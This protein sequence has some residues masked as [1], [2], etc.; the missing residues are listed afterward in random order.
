[1]Q[2][3]VPNGAASGDDRFVV[4]REPDLEGDE[5]PALHLVC[6]HVLGDVR[7]LPELRG[8]AGELQCLAER[9]A[10]VGRVPG[11]EGVRSAA[12]D[13]PVRRGRVRIS[14]PG[15]GRMSLSGQHVCI[16]MHR[17]PG[18]PQMGNRAIARDG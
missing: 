11:D 16:D 15:M 12:A 2:K 7:D 3:P 10:V 5:V 8:Q 14:E 4:L 17:K 18:F 13:G 1:M 9:D 6:P